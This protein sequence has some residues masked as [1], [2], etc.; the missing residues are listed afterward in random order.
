[1][2]KITDI[3]GIEVGHSTHPTE[4]TGCTMILCREGAVAGVDIRGSA[5]GTRETELLR[6]T[7]LIRKIHG[8]MLSG[9]SAFGLRTADG[10]M[11]WC[12]ENDIGYD[13]RG[14]IVP[15]IPAAILFDL[16]ESRN[17]DFPSVEMGYE[18]CQAAGK[19]FA[20][21]LVGAGR[22]ATVGKILGRQYCMNGGLASAAMKLPGGVIVGALA[23]VNALGDVVNPKNGEIVA[24]A[25]KADGSGF[26]DSVHTV[27]N[28]GF[29]TNT[30]ES[31]TTLA[32]VATNARFSK[33][34]INKIAAMAQNGIARATRPA[35]TM[36]DGDVV[37]A[38][39]LG[40]KHADV[41]IVGEIAAM[42][43]AE[44]IVRA[45]TLGNQQ[46]Q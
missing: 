42:M 38:L 44:A 11:K 37:F 6:P 27:I 32:V 28:G 19:D 21:G 45:V 10:A 43:V 23:V 24:G 7:N 35:H 8:I 13:A 2:L 36:H 9:G 16:T 18:A 5:P 25:R 33:E 3:E 22:G 26:V 39:S 46:S 4:A 40:S 34:E 31:N 14:I 12:A 29:P 17:T 20:E 41:S 15:I 1:M 30:A